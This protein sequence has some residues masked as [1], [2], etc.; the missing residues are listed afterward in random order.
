LKVIIGLWLVAYE[1]RYGE[2]AEDV[3]ARLLA[4]SA[5]TIDRLLA[6]IRARRRRGLCATRSARHLQ[7]QIPIRTRFQEVD[8]PGWLEADTVAH[9]G[10]SLAGSFLWSVTLTDIFSGWTEIRA[11]WNRSSREIVRHLREIEARLAFEIEGL[12]SDNGSEFLNHN[13]YR[14]LRERDVPIEFTRSRPYRKND[15]AHVEQK[16]W[17]HVRQLLGYDRLEKRCLVAM[18]NDLYRNEWCL[19]QNFFQPTMQL[20]SKSREGG[21]LRRF[22]SAPRTPYARLMESPVVDADS[23]TAL[24]EEFEHLDPFALH[25]E[26]ER[27]LRAIFRRA[28]GRKRQERTGPRAFQRQAVPTAP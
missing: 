25:D 26:I 27:K 14:Y 9:C 15:N 7:G 24:R 21:R 23:K 8:G 18:V 1:R 6:P 5:A 16:Q 22:H 13:V 2:L 20:V 12:D 28:R 19:L 11:V 3:R 10:E 17:T 4:I